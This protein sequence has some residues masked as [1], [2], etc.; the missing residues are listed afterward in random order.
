MI[1]KEQTE[2][3]VDERKAKRLRRRARDKLQDEA[4]QGGAFVPAAVNVD[5]Q[6]P[7]DEE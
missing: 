5:A 3:E 1:E 4:A 6:V 2:Q 7:V